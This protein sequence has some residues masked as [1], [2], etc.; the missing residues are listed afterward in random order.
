M[1][2][3]I[4]PEMA[5]W[6]KE[7]TPKMED[8]QTRLRII[9]PDQRDNK[10]INDYKE[11]FVSRRCHRMLIK[12]GWGSGKTLLSKKLAFDWAKGTFKTFA[13]VFRVPKMLVNPSI[14]IESIIAKQYRLEG[15]P[16]SEEIVEQ[17]LEKFRE[18]VL[19]IID[20]LNDDV[21]EANKDHF[22]L[23]EMPDFSKV[24]VLVTSD[25][26]EARA[27][28]KDFSTVREIQN[29]NP[30]EREAY[31]RTFSKNEVNNEAVLELDLE[32]PNMRFDSNNCNPMVTMFL[33]LIVDKIGATDKL[34]KRMGLWEIYLKLIL[35]LSGSLDAL[36][37]VGHYTWNLLG[38]KA[39]PIEGTNVATYLDL[40]LLIS[41]SG[42]DSL[43]FPQRTIKI[44]SGALY[45]IL[46]LSEGNVLA[47]ILGSDCKEPIFVMDQLFLYFCLS[48]L[49]NPS[50]LEISDADSVM[51]KLQLF[52]VEKANNN[53]LDLSDFAEIYPALK[54]AWGGTE[55]D[56]LVKNFLLNVLTHC[57]NIKSLVLGS[58]IPIND[59]LAAIQPTLSELQKIHIGD[60]AEPSEACIPKEVGE[61]EIHVV[62]NDL[63]EDKIETLLTTLGKTQKLICI[64]VIY[65]EA[66]MLDLA[67]LFRS[68]VVR[69]HVQQTS[70]DQV[71]WSVDDEIYPCPSLKYLHLSSYSLQ[72]H[73]KTLTALSKGKLPNLSHLSFVKMQQFGNMMEFLFNDPW[74]KLRS[75]HILQTEIS[76][77]DMC[78]LA[79]FALRELKELSIS[80]PN[81]PFQVPDLPSLQKLRVKYYTKG[82]FC[83]GLVKGRFPSVVDLQLSSSYTGENDK[84][85]AEADVPKL[86]RLKLSH[87]RGCRPVD[88]H[89]IAT[90]S[91]ITQLTS[92]DLTNNLLTDTLSLLLFSKFPK[93]KNLVISGCNL[94]RG[95]LK[96]L[97]QAN[98]KSKFPKL[99][100]LDI[101]RNR[102]VIVAFEELQTAASKWESLT[103]INVYTHGALPETAALSVLSKVD[104]F[105][106]LR[107]LGF[108]VDKNSSLPEHATVWPLLET[109]EV[110]SDLP[111]DQALRPI[112]RGKEKGFFPSLRTVRVCYPSNTP[113]KSGRSALKHEL[114]SKG[115]TLQFVIL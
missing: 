15:L 14:P 110:Y 5:P 36:K 37:S 2:D 34:E 96:C 48:L 30:T 89:L 47:D 101:S 8:I 21:S 52:V 78:Y 72:A 77:Q 83:Q 88:V 66:A 32:I 95:D 3:T 94:S 10:D 38:K 74:P 39:H 61:N 105:P 49:E 12:G 64:Y 114:R 65:F 106:K 51:E 20:S 7:Y 59:I 62:V 81:L 60:Y 73:E 102:E 28:E 35:T 99:E 16:A 25:P 112:V 108:S 54:T 63:S 97:I 9:R 33:C 31:L 6:A 69:V 86:E 29:F 43:K 90:N 55:A 104:C 67:V 42:V 103:K 85:F 109:V 113:R 82:I 17:I 93:L 46:L 75:L 13:V 19:I 18:R 71:T 87:D 56:I 22:V 1:L 80:D 27:I 68:K 100:V 111:L 41:H 44:F 45:F 84:L 23:R 70:S 115:V 98:K 11:L 91:S 4:K 57:T 53:Q 40:G 24:S 26:S 79:A 58:K 107:A 50:T 92:L 76:Y